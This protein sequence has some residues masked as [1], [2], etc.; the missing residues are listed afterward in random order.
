MI[1]PTPLRKFPSF[2]KFNFNLILSTAQQK[3]HAHHDHASAQFAFRGK[4]STLVS[5]FDDVL[6]AKSIIRF[7][8][9]P[10][11]CNQRPVC[12]P[13]KSPPEYPTKPDYPGVP[14]YPWNP[15]YPGQPDYPKPDYPIND[16]N[17]PWDEKYP[18]YPETP[19]DQW[20]TNNQPWRRN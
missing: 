19:Q 18:K 16:P 10:C 11:R 6:I 7:P 20:N 13:E 3:G 2:N 9:S 17:K 8:C 14:E 12:P 4:D 5:Y 1:N 15:D